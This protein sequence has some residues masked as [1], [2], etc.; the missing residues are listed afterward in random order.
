MKHVVVRNTQLLSKLKYGN[1]TVDTI[2]VDA[3]YLLRHYKTD[4]ANCTGSLVDWSADGR[5]FFEGYFALYPGDHGFNA[6]NVLCNF[7]TDAL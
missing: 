4:S 1:G 3:F 7:I 6:G 2:D 5:N